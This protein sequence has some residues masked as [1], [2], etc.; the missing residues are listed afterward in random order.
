LISHLLEENYPVLENEYSPEII[1]KRLIIIFSGNLH[2]YMRQV[3][4]QLINVRSVSFDGPE[5]KSVVIQNIA[6]RGFPHFSET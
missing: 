3:E 2:N 1:K 6:G 4:R 5:A